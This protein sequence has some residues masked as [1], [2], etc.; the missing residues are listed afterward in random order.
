M[1]KLKLERTRRAWWLVLLIPGAIGLAGCNPTAAAVLFGMPNKPVP[2]EYPGLAG[3]KRDVAIVVYT[4]ESTELEDPGL[5]GD[6]QRS[7]AKSLD[8]FSN[9][10]FISPTAIHEYQRQNFYWT[11]TPPADIGKKLSADMVLCLHV[12][13]Y[14]LTQPRQAYYMQGQITCRCILVDV[15]KKQTVWEKPDLTITFPPKDNAKS[16]TISAEVTRKELLRQFCLKL[17]DCFRRH[18]EP[19]YE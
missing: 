14:A 7:V 15:K 16:M 12:E 19:M 5:A 11:D 8:S 6:L 3:E 2:A 9:L 4:Q 1:R 13:Y 17:A 10:T 18:E